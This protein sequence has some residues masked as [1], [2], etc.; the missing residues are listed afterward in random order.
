MRL[1][2]QWQGWPWPGSRSSCGAR[3][4]PVRRVLGRSLEGLGVGWRADLAPAAAD[5]IQRRRPWLRLL[6]APLAVRRHD[7][8]RRADVSYGP[9]G[10]QNLLDL[11]LPRSGVATGPCLVYFHGGGYRS[12]R[13]NREGRALL[14]R[15]ASQGWVCLSANYR[16][17]RSAPYPAALVDAKRAIAWLRAQ[18]PTYAA[19]PSMLVVAGSSAGAH[20]A[21]LTALTSNLATLQPGFEQADTRVSAAVCLY[22]FYGAP[23]WI[24]RDLG[25]PSAPIDYVGQDAPPMLIVHGTHDSFVPVSGARQFAQ[26]VR[27]AGSPSPLVYLELPGAQHTFDLYHSVRVHAVMDTVDAFAASVLSDAAAELRR[28]SGPR[29][30]SANASPAAALSVRQPRERE[31]S[32]D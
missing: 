10:Q 13:K 19:D 15:L 14:Y 9:A 17:A 11:Y 20:L 31:G 4:W 29:R 25:A 6:F 12:G 16:L 21:A 5:R 28:S 32:P 2:W 23:T 24:E 3:C 8:L 22:G 30:T 18:A 26:R 7:V 27:A 1:R